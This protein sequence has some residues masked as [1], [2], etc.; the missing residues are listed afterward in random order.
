MLVQL[1]ADRNLPFLPGT[2]DLALVIHPLTLSL[3]A[4]VPQ[5]LRRGGYLVLETFGA[6]GRNWRAL[7]RPREV[8][9]R[10]SSDFEIIQYIERNVHLDPPS[11]TVKAMLRKR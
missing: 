4:S 8:S 10:L 6:Q 11:V 2:F 5:T 9:D 3:L 7:P 1:D